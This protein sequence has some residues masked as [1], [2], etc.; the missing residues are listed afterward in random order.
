MNFTFQPEFASL[1]AP[2]NTVRNQIQNI[3]FLLDIEIGLL[4]R[5]LVLHEKARE[6]PDSVLHT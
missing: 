5:N 1:E 6:D 3:V 4:E 2:K